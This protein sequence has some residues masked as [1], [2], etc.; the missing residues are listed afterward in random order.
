M[1][2]LGETIFDLLYLASVLSMGFYIL[3]C[4]KKREEELMGYSLIVL[5]FGDAFHLI[6]RIISYN[7]SFNFISILGIGKLIT[8]IT[9]T[10][11]YLFLYYIFL[12]NYEEKKKKSMSI[13]IWFLLILRIILCLF[14]ENGWLT[15]KNTIEWSII[16]NVPF[17]IIGMLITFLYFRKRK[18]DKYLKFI[19]IYIF[20]S[21][22]FYIPV[23][24]L[25][26]SMPSIGLLMIP[27]T[28]CYILISISFFRKVKNN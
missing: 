27:K 15:G 14:M 7:F 1:K 22:V 21:F 2:E 6:P 4:Y 5:G 20:L 13:V 24:L 9:M 19:W 25:S 28:I 3:S 16:R 12:L 11:F 26:N 17:I 18:D 8:S 23:I 10:I